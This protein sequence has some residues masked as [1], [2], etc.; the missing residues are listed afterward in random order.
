MGTNLQGDKATRGTKPQ[1]GEQTGD[2][3]PRLLVPHYH[4]VLALK[5]LRTM[6]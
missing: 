2:I 4:Q 6:R 5:G 1:G 3:W